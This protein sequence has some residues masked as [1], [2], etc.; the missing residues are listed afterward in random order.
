MRC[1]H[2]SFGCARAFAYFFCSS[3]RVVMPS[4]VKRDPPPL[5]E[6]KE[7]PSDWLAEVEMEAT[8]PE[9]EQLAGN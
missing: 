4:V 5:K 8:P 9:Q 7:K 2:C 6:P 1:F 3:F